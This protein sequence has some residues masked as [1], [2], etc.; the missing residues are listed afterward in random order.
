MKTIF[1][2]SPYL[3]IYKYVT[4][5][6]NKNYFFREKVVGKLSF[7]IVYDSSFQAG[8]TAYFMLLKTVNFMKY[9]GARNLEN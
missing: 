1:I 9:L 2:S 5:E 7:Y 8:K 6:Q 3:G 4:L